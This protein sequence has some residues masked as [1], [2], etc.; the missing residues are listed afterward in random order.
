MKQTFSLETVLKRTAAKWDSVLIGCCVNLRPRDNKEAEIYIKVNRFLIVT[1]NKNYLYYK[2][3]FWHIYS[4]KC[5][6]KNKTP[7]TSE[8]RMSTNSP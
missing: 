3:I 5:T 2:V 6:V 1:N 7:I 4:T 8:A